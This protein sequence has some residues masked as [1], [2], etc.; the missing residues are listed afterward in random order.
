MDIFYTNETLYVNMIEAV[1]NLNFTRMKKKVYKILEDYKIQ[2]IE[3]KFINDNNI[4]KE[5]VDSFIEES[6]CKYHAKVK[7][8]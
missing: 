4:N 5:I 7:Y 2:N 6:K 1:D 8:K 3:L